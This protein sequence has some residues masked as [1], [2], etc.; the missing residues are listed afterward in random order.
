LFSLYSLK[1][2]PNASVYVNGFNDQY[3]GLW[4]VASS[5]LNVYTQPTD[6]QRYYYA[7]VYDTACLIDCYDDYRLLHTTAYYCILLHTTAYYC[8]LLHTIA[9]YCILLQMPPC[10][11]YPNSV[12]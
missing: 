11:Y 1:A 2:E 10:E 6:G 9:Y 5:G 3:D 4:A 8:I 7:P 12:P